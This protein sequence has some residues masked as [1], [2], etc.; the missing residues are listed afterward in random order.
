LIP[1]LIA[2][3]KKKVY[4]QEEFEVRQQSHRQKTKDKLEIA[5]KEMHD[6]VKSMYEVFRFD[7]EGRTS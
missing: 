7:S 4:K 6:L 1:S 5:H 3:R 2:N